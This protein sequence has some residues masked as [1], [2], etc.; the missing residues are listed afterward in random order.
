[1]PQSLHALPEKSQHLLGGLQPLPCEVWPG[2]AFTKGS[3]Q[4]TVGQE[5]QDFTLLNNDVPGPGAR[6][7]DK[8]LL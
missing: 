6:R 5:A 1:M 3:E 2:Q 4:H 7:V 8:I